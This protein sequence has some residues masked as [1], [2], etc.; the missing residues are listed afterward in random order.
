ERSRV[1]AGRV[2]SDD[3]AIEPPVAP[4]V[5]GPVPVD[6]DVVADVVPAVAADVPL[7]DAAHDARGFG[8][9]V[10]VGPGSV[11]DHG[12]ADGGVRGRAS[13]QRLLGTPLRT[14]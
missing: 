4:L 14:G 1:E 9:G 13:T 12:E 6:Q 10:A 7:V 5:D 2:C 3:A 8:S 11:V